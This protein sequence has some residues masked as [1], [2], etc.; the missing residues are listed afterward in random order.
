[1][2]NRIV[3]PILIPSTTNY[4]GYFDRAETNTFHGRY[5][6]VSAPYVINDVNADA[7]TAPDDV[8]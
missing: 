3:P 4:Q 1:M 2:A 6:A 5:V 7:A 8:T